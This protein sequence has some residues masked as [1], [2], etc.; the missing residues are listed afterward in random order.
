MQGAPRGELRVSAPISFG[1]RH[2]APAVSDFLSTYPDVSAHLQLD[3]RYVELVAE[4]F[5]LAVRIGDM[6]DSSLM[7]KKLGASRS[8]L[9]ASDDYLRRYGTPK[10]TED[11]ADHQ[12]LHYSYLSSGNYW[13]LRTPAGAE[14][15]VRAGGRL[16]VNNGDALIEAAVSGL[17]IVLSPMFIAA[18]AIAS[19][20][21]RE[22]VLDAEAASLG[23]FAVYPAGR[24]P[25]PKVRAFIDFMAERFSGRG[26][27]WLDAG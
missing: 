27:D 8:V 9:V 23:I 7:A 2:L 17:G 16:S 18:P 24:F 1:I 11:L 12:L 21:I 19:G 10:K 4:G 3:D 22:I 15:Q 6:P 13:R 20:Q 5:D 26:E 25:S 14:R